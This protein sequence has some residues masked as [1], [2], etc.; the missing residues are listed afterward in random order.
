MLIQKGI[1]RNTSTQQG[2]QAVA[3][4]AAQS[5]AEHVWARLCQSTSTTSAPFSTIQSRP[6]MPASRTP[7]ST[8]RLHK[9]QAALSCRERSQE[10]KPTM[11][12]VLVAKR[13]E[14]LVPDLLGTEEHQA[15]LLIVHS[16]E[17]PALADLHL[18]A[19][20]KASV[21]S[22]AWHRPAG[23]LPSCGFHASLHLLS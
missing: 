14:F 21:P 20:S 17:V 11:Q 19:C 4:A 9:Q 1:R 16:Q 6:Q 5:H 22:P 3:L 8:Y 7:S 23:V 18:E 10:K 12:G 2:S 15:Q 13:A